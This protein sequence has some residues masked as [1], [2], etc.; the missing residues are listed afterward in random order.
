MWVVMTGTTTV[1]SSPSPPGR[2]TGRNSTPIATNV[3]TTSYTDTGRTNG[4]TY[5]YKVAAVNA[6][7]VSPQSNEASATP[8]P[9]QPTAPSAPTGLTAVAGNGSVSLSWTAPASNGG[10]AITGYNVYRG[11]T[12]GGE[13]PTPIATNVPGTSFTDTGETNGR[14]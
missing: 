6:V 5:Y 13:S 11:T 3:T 10:S 8:Q 14:T 1:S 12:A 7:G 9:T 4:T 2:A